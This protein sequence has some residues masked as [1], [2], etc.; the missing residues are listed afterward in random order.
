[1][2]VN[3]V[4]PEEWAKALRQLAKRR[5]VSL[6]RLLCESAAR[7]L[8]KNE[9]RKLPPLKERGRPRKSG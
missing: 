9:L 5:G 3:I 4:M 1:M 7:D 6:S 8:P 2:P